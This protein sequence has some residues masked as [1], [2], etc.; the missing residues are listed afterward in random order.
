MSAREA[1]RSPGGS[2]DVD[3]GC[4]GVHVPDRDAGVCRVGC[5]FI[6]HE[7]SR[8]W[9]R[10]PRAV[11]F[12]ST[13]RVSCA[14]GGAAL[15]RGARG[16]F[17]S[18][19]LRLVSATDGARRDSRAHEPIRGRSDGGGGAWGRA[20]TRGDGQTLLRAR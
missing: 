12:Q 17:W 19:K 9:S 6:E 5:G 13:P 20:S 1:G 16:I 15:A 7:S 2:G 8:R 14:L 10:P 3:T 4:A 11:A 18:R